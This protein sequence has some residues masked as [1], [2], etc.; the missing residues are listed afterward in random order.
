[1]RVPA[2]AQDSATASQRKRRSMLSPDETLIESRSY[3]RQNSRRIRESVINL[4]P[5]PGRERCF[6]YRANA[7]RRTCRPTGRARTRPTFCATRSKHA[8]M[9]QRTNVIVCAHP[10][11]L[12]KRTQEAAAQAVTQ[13]MAR[14]SNLAA[15]VR[16]KTRSGSA[17]PAPPARRLSTR[18]EF[19]HENQAFQ[20]CAGALR[21]CAHARRHAV[22]RRPPAFAGCGGGGGDGSN[23]SSS[24]AAPAPALPPRRL[25]RRPIPRTRP[26][27]PAAMRARRSRP[28]CRWPRR[29][30]RPNRRSIT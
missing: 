17:G 3:A 2:S 25:P 26:R 11:F 1:M 4:P 9:L 15:T 18:I 23:P 12:V 19:Q 29:P 16:Q 13:C 30:R 22:R 28:P 6:P 24:N 20:F 5:R 10:G 27:R 21:T 14:R 7:P 8:F